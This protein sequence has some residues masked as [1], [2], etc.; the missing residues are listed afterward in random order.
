MKLPLVPGIQ[1]QVSMAPPSRAS[2]AHALRQD[3][4]HTSRQAPELS[5]EAQQFADSQ[6]RLRD[7]TSALHDRPNS[8]S[9]GA[10]TRLLKYSGQLRTL[11]RL[12]LGCCVVAAK[13]HASP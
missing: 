9:K 5:S 10:H 8:S 13:N 3:L 2:H 12:G 4:D 1:V 11:Q 6:L 7:A